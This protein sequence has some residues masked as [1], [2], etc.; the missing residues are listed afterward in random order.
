MPLGVDDGKL[1]GGA[2]MLQSTVVSDI[3]WP[4]FAMQVPTGACELQ[5]RGRGS[6]RG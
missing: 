3:N 5:F 4:Q 1:L 6:R 2:M